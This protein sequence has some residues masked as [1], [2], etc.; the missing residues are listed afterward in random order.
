MTF[1][2]SEDENVLPVVME[3]RTLPHYVELSALITIPQGTTYEQVQ[4]EF[5][6]ISALG[7]AP[8][9]SDVEQLTV[10]HVIFYTGLT[11]DNLTMQ[12]SMV[13]TAASDLTLK[14]FE[15]NA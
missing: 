7:L 10:R 11:S 15:I 9:S 14:I 13:V 6:K 8:A 3:V 2:M 12:L 1:W 5:F 4:S